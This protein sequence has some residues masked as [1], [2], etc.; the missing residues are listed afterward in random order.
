MFEQ[1]LSLISSRHSSRSFA[2]KKV[3][4]DVIERILEAAAKSPSSQNNQPWSVVVVTGEPLRILSRRL[5]DAYDAKLPPTPDYKNR[6]DMSSMQQ[7]GIDAFAHHWFT[8]SNG[9]ERDDTQGRRSVHRG[10]FSFFGATTHLIVSIPA[11]SAE[12]TFID[13]GMYVQNILILAHAAGL[14]ALPQ[15]SVASYANLIRESVKGLIGRTIICGISLG[16]T[17]E[18][19]E[20]KM[21]PVRHDTSEYVSWLGFEDFA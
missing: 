15:Y 4:R 17:N 11:E 14:G 9:L 21:G 3:P 10:N 18:P 13:I 1:A 6:S 12:G 2:P 20:G 19:L 5:L 8:K 16:Y 7:K